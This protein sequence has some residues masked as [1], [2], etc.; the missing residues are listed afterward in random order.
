MG[1]C[2]HT[3]KPNRDMCKDSSS[4]SSGTNPGGSCSGGAAPCPNCC[5]C[6]TTGT[7]Q[8]ITAFNNGS[9]FGHQYDFVIQ[10]AYSAGTAGTRDC[11]LEWWENTT[12]PYFAVNTPNTWTQLHGVVASPVF[13]PWD[14]RV[15]PCPGGGSLTVT[16]TDPP[17]LG[18][19]PGRTAQRTLKFR[20]KVISGSGCPCGQASATATATQVLEII[21]GVPNGSGTF[22]TP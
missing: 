5:C 16:L 8:N 22:T 6:A 2:W 4:P 1:A 7:I 3:W 19:V 20:L 17:G 10:I 15:V 13:D 21:N 18:I 12:I 9:Q 14:H 11:T